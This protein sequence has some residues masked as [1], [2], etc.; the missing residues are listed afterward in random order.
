MKVERR[1]TVL[2]ASLA[3][4]GALSLGALMATPAAAAPRHVPAP[5]CILPGS[6]NGEGGAPEIC[7]FDDY[8]KCSQ[9]AAEMQAH[10]V[11]NIDFPG[12]VVRSA[13]GWRAVY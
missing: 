2:A 9:A 4:A 7:H 3:V 11:V 12:Q 8:Q 1:T 10:C 6:S 5:F 13:N